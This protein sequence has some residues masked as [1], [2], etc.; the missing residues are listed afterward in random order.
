MIFTM[1]YIAVKECVGTA[2]VYKEWGAAVL[3]DGVLLFHSVPAVC[4]RLL[5]ARIEGE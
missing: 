2:Q 1:H 5:G 3:A 4:S